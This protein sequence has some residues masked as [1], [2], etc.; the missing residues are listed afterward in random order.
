VKNRFPT[1]GLILLLIGCA[2]AEPQACQPPRSYWQKPHNLVGLMPP[3]NIISLLRDGSI[4][5]NGKQV[6]SERLSQYLDLSHGMNP[7]PNIF[8]QTEMGVPCRKL[9]AVRDQMDRSLECKKA[10]SHCAEGVLSVWKNLPTPPGS[11]V[12]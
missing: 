7:E 12:S 5:W 11:V 2:R 1:V 10:Y 4:D 3:M 6:S 8:L 9:E